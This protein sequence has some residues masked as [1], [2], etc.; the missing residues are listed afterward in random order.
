MGFF[1]DEELLQLKIK[2]MILHVVGDGGFEAQPELPAVQQE[3]FFLARIGEI[4]AS[5]LFRFEA[6]SA[7]KATL[8]AMA[9][10]KQS[11]QMGGQALAGAF[12]KSH[13]GASKDGAF[14]VFELMPL[15]AGVKLYAMFKIDYKS[16]IERTRQDGAVQLR[17]IIEAF[18]EDRKAVQKS[19]LIK[20]AHGVA[21][22]DVSAKDRIGQAPN[23]TD[24]FQRFLGVR[25]ERSDEELNKSALS[26]VRNALNDVQSHLPQKDVGKAF[27]LAKDALRHRQRIDTKAIHEAVLAALGPD[28][29]DDAKAAINAAVER[30]IRKQRLTGL[31]FKPNAQ[32]LR[33]SPRRRVKTVE[34]VVIEYPAELEDV[35]VRR[36]THKDGRATLT[37]DTKHIEHDVL[38]PDKT[39]P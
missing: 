11:F 13:V 18:I 15:D 19:C 36:V 7:T 23:L 32:A 33:R 20:V 12:S 38:V 10:G 28:P 30:Q 17:K 34:G 24:Y 26:G 6:G 9:T 37:I 5:G 35:S 3:E 2:K 29:A 27:A 39:V 8:E 4:N 25:R 31:A 16:A 14:F 21:L 22:A 1:T